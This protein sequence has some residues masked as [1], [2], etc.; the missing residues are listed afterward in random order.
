MHMS[1]ALT[2]RSEYNCVK[3]LTTIEYSQY[4]M[5]ASI[6][7]EKQDLAISTDH[8]PIQF[9]QDGFHYVP[10]HPGFGLAKVGNWKE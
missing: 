7:H 2:D 1:Q 3:S 4:W 6:V 5:T 8:L 9:G 10:C